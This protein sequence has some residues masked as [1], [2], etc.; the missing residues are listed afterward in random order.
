M[1]KLKSNK[2]LKS[3]LTIEEKKMGKTHVYILLGM[4][5]IGI[6]IGLYR[7]Q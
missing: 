2:K 5:V 4:I 3:H 1:S 6:A 7:M